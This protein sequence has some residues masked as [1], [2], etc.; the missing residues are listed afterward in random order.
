M[1]F[2]LSSDEYFLMMTAKVKEAVTLRIA[3]VTKSDRR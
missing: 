2:Y 3:R 1:A